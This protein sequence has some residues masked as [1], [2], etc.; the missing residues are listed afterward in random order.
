MRERWWR[1]LEPAGGHAQHEGSEQQV[2][3]GGHTPR[4]AV[5]GIPV[6]AALVRTVAVVSEAAL[7][8]GCS[9][10]AL[11]LVTES[12]VGARLHHRV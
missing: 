1:C 5:L 12:L 3:A 2:G 7:H 9:A 4:A 6:A 8:L 10:A 11:G